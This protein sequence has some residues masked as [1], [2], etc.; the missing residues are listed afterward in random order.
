MAP[1]RFPS[2]LTALLVDSTL[3]GP[4]ATLADAVGTILD[5]KAMPFFPAFT[6][7]GTGH[8]EQVLDATVKLTPEKIWKK[9]IFQPADAAVLTCAAMLHDL[10]MH[11]HP[12]GFVELVSEG[13]RFEPS[14]WFRDEHVDRPADLPWPEL[15]ANFQREA[16]H[17]GTSQLELLFGAGAKGVPLVAHE[18]ELDPHG[19]EEGD[20][21]LI[22]EF[23]RRHHARLSHEIALYGF[24]GLTDEQF[25]ILAAT[26]PDLAD[27]VGALARSHNEPLRLMLDYLTFLEGGSKRPGGALL[28][29]HMGLLRIADYV[30]LEASRAPALLLRLRQPVSQLSIEE[31]NKHEAVSSIEWDHDDPQAIFVRVS[32]R[33]TLRTHLALGEL[34][35]ELQRE[36]DTTTAVFDVIYPRGK[37]ATLR[38]TRQRVLTNLNEPS[39]Q[40]RLPY[41]AKRAS[42]RSDADLFRLVIRD[43]YGNQPSVAGREMV[44]N[45]VDAVRARRSAEELGDFTTSPEKFRDLEADVV[46]S[47]EEEKGEQCVLRVSDRGIGMTPIL[48]VDYFLQA[49]ASFGP[50]VPE[51]EELR[52]SEALTSMRAGR[53]GV[54]AFAGFLLGPEIE[55]TTRHL[56][57]GRGIRFK[58]RIDGDLVQLNWEDDAPIGTE[59]TVCFDRSVIPGPQ[60]APETAGTPQEFLQRIALFYRLDDPTVAFVHR[61][62]SSVEYVPAV[63]DIPLPEKPLPRSWRSASSENFDAILWSAEPGTA[64]LTHNGIE[65]RDLSLGHRGEGSYEWSSPALLSILRRPRLAIFDSRHLLRV[66]LHRYSLLERRLPFED[67]LLNSIGT[68][69]LARGL[70]LGPGLHPAEYPDISP[71]FGQVDWMPLLPSLARS[72]LKGPLLVLWRTAMQ[73]DMSARRGVAPTPLLKPDSPVPW[74]IFPHRAD[75]VVPHYTNNDIAAAAAALSQRLGGRALAT[76]SVSR[77][78]PRAE[79]FSPPSAAPSGHGRASFTQ[80]N[81][82]MST[83]GVDPGDRRIEKALQEAAQTLLGISRGSVVALSAFGDFQGIGQAEEAL[84]AAWDATLGGGLSRTDDSRDEVVN[85]ALEENPDLGT[86]LRA[87]RN[88]TEIVSSA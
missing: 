26:M 51:V 27:S 67:E 80:R 88:V 79:M 4:T 37:L 16:R 12:G 40:E 66:A 74:D 13:T 33:H 5:A 46:V 49:G 82:G 53:F 1:V 42:L 34:L 41:L 69:I 15:W 18:D 22:G 65:I 31:W 8:V 45:A 73:G 71:I 11:I 68:D 17:F 20:L 38:L 36:F 2:K 55:V 43:L 50:T 57:A 14:Q 86:Y 47:I 85:R 70:A 23:L 19:W 75:V 30:Q 78:K 6:D 83:R 87:W 72:Q 61:A 48:V 81:A 58:A 32:A 28:P 35:E 54:G 24:P 77:P 84:G 62:G 39:L 64:Q 52:S 44:Q 63:A 9:K 10:A 3:A 25:P 29:F 21:L 60:W 7:H 56:E 59:V 76:V